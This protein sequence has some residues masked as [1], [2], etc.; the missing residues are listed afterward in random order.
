MKLP[1][2]VGPVFPT[3]SHNPTAFSTVQQ[4]K[5]KARI[6]KKGLKNQQGPEGQGRIAK[7]I[8][9]VGSKAGTSPLRQLCR[10]PSCLE[11]GAHGGG[12]CSQ[13]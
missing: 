10:A 13:N 2:L 4:V 1:P 5:A 7:N 6:T 3:L 8:Y 9:N 11:F 12:V